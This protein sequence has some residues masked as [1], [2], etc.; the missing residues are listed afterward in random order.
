MYFDLEKHHLYNYR[1]VAGSFFL[2]L[3]AV[4]II[5]LLGVANAE[6]QFK[7]LAV[8]DLAYYDPLGGNPGGLGQGTPEE[9]PV[10]QPAS[11]SESRPLPPELFEPEPVSVSVPDDIFPSFLESTSEEAIPV[12][13]P[14]PP[15]L[16][17]KPKPKP[18]PKV[19]Q[20][21]K[22]VNEPRTE[23]VGQTGP[24]AVG[25]G[26]GG[27]A[28][29]GPGDGQ[30]GYGGGTGRGSPKVLDAYV[31]KVRLRLDRKKKYPSEAAARNLKGIVEINF[32]ISQD[33]QVT[34][35][36]IVQGSGHSSLDDEV[37]ALVRR[38]S[39]LPPIPAEINRTSL[40]LT[41]PVQ[42]SRR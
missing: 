32:T 9:G 7:P 1:A 3:G 31:S 4:S 24:T 5:V 27:G 38:V 40:N 28:G 37:M 21:Q 26:P 6:H 15:E 34:R 2:H 10:D 35:P 39:P 19:Q 17:E 14:P 42:F 25:G 18:K 12:T 29:G 41:V 22:T 23:T 8:M 11:E 36:R 16:V 13:P 20:P 30:G 33:G